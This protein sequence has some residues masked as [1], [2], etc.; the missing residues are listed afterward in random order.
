VIINKKERVVYKN[1]LPQ[2]LYDNG[3]RDEIKWKN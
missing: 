2:I 3:E 1:L